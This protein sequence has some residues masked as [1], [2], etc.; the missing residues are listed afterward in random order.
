[1][2]DTATGESAKRRWAIAPYFHV[3][4]VVS[5]ANWYRDKLG[6]AYDRFWVTRRA[7]AWSGGGAS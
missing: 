4:D 3:D 5:T 1:M 2:T 6:F 7:S